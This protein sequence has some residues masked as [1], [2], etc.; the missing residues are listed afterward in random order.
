MPAASINDVFCFNSLKGIFPFLQG[1]MLEIWNI[2]SS[3]YWYWHNKCKRLDGNTRNTGEVESKSHDCQARAI[4]SLER[5]NKDVATLWI[6]RGW[7]GDGKFHC[8]LLLCIWATRNIFSLPKYVFKTSIARKHLEKP[9][10]W[11]RPCYCNM[12]FCGE[13]GLAKSLHLF[14]SLHLSNTANK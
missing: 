11:E 5:V 8:V 10:A 9:S 4:L 7:K 1:I 6:R 14:L 2:E 3:F 12:H 13:S